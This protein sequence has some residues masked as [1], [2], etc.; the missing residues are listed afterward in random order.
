LRLLY[1]LDCLADSEE[2]EQSTGG[3][4]LDYVF[5][6]EADYEAYYDT[7]VGRHP[8]IDPDVTPAQ[9]RA[10][11]AKFV[12]EIVV[13]CRL[14]DEFEMVTDSLYDVL[15]IQF[16]YS[17]ANNHS[18]EQCWSCGRLFLQTPFAARPFK[19]FCSARCKQ[20]D[21][22]SRVA[23]A[24]DLYEHGHTPGVIAKR[25]RTNA[26]QVRKWIKESKR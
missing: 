19:T 8:Y 21:Y 25:L 15:W 6:D 9:L 22:R 26:A 2:Y 14:N 3:L 12:A 4:G 17:M 13:R 1:H 20:R 18:I 11:A 23:E 16:A 7:A 10:S 5:A 24:I